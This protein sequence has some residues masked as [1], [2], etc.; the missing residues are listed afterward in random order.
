MDQCIKIILSW[1]EVIFKSCVYFY[2]NIAIIIAWQFSRFV[3]RGFFFH[4]VSIS[5]LWWSI[6][7]VRKWQHVYIPP[8]SPWCGSDWI[9][10]VCF[11]GL[12]GCGW[13]DFACFG[14]D[15][16]CRFG[17]F[18]ALVGFSGF[19]LV[20]LGLDS[21]WIGLVWVGLCFVCI[22]FGW[23][24]LVWF[25]FELVLFSLVLIWIGF[26]W[27]CLVWIGFGWLWFVLVWLWLVGFKNHNFCYVSIG[28]FL[29]WSILFLTWTD[30]KVE[31]EDLNV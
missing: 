26:G 13:V 18:V 17:F 28:T 3:R 8:C 29:V 10:W 21:I 5:I 7:G 24:C 31:V 20:Y 22:G 30:V 12:I 25:W 2:K 6:I 1:I 9:V 15:W 23:F 4:V 14:L 19:G 27:V 16:L 11:N